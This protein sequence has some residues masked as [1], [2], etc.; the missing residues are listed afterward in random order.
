M[1]FGPPPP[2]GVGFLGFFRLFLE[3]FRRMSVRVLKLHR[4]FILTKKGDINPQQNL[5]PPSGPLG[6]VFRVLMFFFENFKI[7]PRVLK[8]RI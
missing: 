1:K 2:S 8:L 3:N 7:C 6:G 4:G 5:E